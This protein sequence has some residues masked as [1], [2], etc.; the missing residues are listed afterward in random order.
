VGIVEELVEIWPNEVCDKY[1]SPPGESSE[2]R[3]RLLERYS[4]LYTSFGVRVS[5]IG[6]KLVCLSTTSKQAK[7]ALECCHAIQGWKWRCPLTM[8]IAD[9]LGLELSH[10]SNPSLTRFA[11]NPQNSNSVLDLVFFPPDNSGFGKYIL[12]PEI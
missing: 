3:M 1:N 7:V 8:T 11:D 2:I 6:A 12:H 4:T 9:S 10:P 5:R